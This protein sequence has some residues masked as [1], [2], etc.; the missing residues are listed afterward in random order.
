MI[1]NSNIVV[2]VSGRSEINF[3]VLFVVS[4]IV[5][6]DVFLVRSIDIKDRI[7]WRTDRLCMGSDDKSLTLLSCKFEPVLISWFLNYSIKSYREWSI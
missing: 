3:A 6:A 4:I 2:T 1:T 7:E 5:P